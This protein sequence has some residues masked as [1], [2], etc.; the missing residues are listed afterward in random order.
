[1]LQLKYKSRIARRIRRKT[2]MSNSDSHSRLNHR[3]PS[4]F[5]GYGAFICRID[6]VHKDVP[7]LTD[8]HQSFFNPLNTFDRH[9]HVVTSVSQRHGRNN[10]CKCTIFVIHLVSFKF[11]TLSWHGTNLV[12]SLRRCCGG[13]RSE[14]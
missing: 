13:M 11:D 2:S 4:E 9:S 6:I 1:M 3:S 7:P 12:Q 14:G 5:L 10:R 8:R